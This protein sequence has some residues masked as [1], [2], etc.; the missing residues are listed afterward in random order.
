MPRSTLAISLAVAIGLAL[1]G[2]DSVKA[3]PAV[4]PPTKPVADTSVLVVHLDQP[5]ACD[6]QGQFGDQMAARIGF[7]SLSR[8]ETAT[9]EAL[10]CLVTSWPNAKYALGNGKPV[11][12]VNAHLEDDVSLGL[13]AIL[14]VNP[15]LFLEKVADHQDVLS[16]WLSSL[17]ETAFIADEPGP[18]PYAD[19]IGDIVR[20]LAAIQAEGKAEVARQTALDGFRTMACYQLN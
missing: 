18:C 7:L 17:S 20:T 16:D 11:A 19:E 8:D 3:P 15:R 9:G 2:C 4:A 13:L 12:T 1:C 6:P 10:D 5:F 14:K